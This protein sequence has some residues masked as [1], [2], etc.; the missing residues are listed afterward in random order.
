MMGVCV[1]AWLPSIGRVLVGLALM[2]S[3]VVAALFMTPFAVVGVFSLGNPALDSNFF[4]R[5]VAGWAVLAFLGWAIWEF[6]S[7]ERTRKVFR[8]R[9]MTANNFR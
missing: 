6:V 9:V 4:L 7:F 8:E 1:E 3:F 2:L 5:V